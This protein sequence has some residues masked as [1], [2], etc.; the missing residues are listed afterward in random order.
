MYDDGFRRS[1]PG[2]GG[3]AYFF[4][5]LLPALAEDGTHAIP[6]NLIAPVPWPRKRTG[7]QSS[8]P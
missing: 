7:R 6:E 8:L 1:V 3:M 2:G 5:F 4:F